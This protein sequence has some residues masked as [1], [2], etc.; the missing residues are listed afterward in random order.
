MPLKFFTFVRYKVGKD[1]WKTEVGIADY[2]Q[3]TLIRTYLSG[4]SY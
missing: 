3:D 1:N 4:H 2:N